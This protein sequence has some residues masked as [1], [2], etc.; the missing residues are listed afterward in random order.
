MTDMSVIANDFLQACLHRKIFLA[1]AESCTGGLIVATLT[2]IPGSSSMVECGFVTYSNE[3]KTKMLGVSPATIEAHGA[4]SEATALEMASGDR[5][6]RRRQC[7]K[8]GRPGLVRALPARQGAHRQ[9]AHI[10]E[11]GTRVHQAGG[12]KDRAE[13]GNRS[14]GGRLT[15]PI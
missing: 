8:A 2:E 12:R 11:Q 13:L 3:A 15:R 7:G 5:G 14:P 6:P 9:K 10:R 4:V 1:T